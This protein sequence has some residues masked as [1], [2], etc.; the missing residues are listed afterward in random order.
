[1]MF[2]I[3][4]GSYSEASFTA[5][6][7][8]TPGPSPP[9]PAAS[10]APSPPPA[11]CSYGN[12]NWPQAAVSVTPGSWSSEVSWT[13]SCVGM[14]ADIQ[15]G[16]PYDEMHS[17]PP[18]AE[19]SLEM[20]D[21]FG[22]GWNGAIWWSGFS[23]EAGYTLETGYGETVSFAANPAPSA[24]VSTPSMLGQCIVNGPCVCSS[25]YP[26]DSC[27]A[28]PVDD[29]D[30]TDSGAPPSGPSQYGNSETCHVEFAQPMMRSVSLFGVEGDTYSCPFDKLEVN[31]V[32]YCGDHSPPRE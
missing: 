9:P 21:S 32:T 20:V 29:Y 22:D 28:D 5:P 26:G 15:G 30:Y 31:G 6:M 10:P 27:N 14:C 19:C 25:N 3:N 7:V 16:A 17:V 12:E 4:S 11:P 24:A 23:D 18:G 2:E 13:L 8:A 1:M